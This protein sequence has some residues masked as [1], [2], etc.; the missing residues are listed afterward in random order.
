MI[1]SSGYGGANRDE[2]ASDEFQHEFIRFLVLA[3]AV[4]LLIA[5]A[6]LSVNEA[7]YALWGQTV[8]AQDFK[9]HTVMRSRNTRQV[10]VVRYTF[11][12]GGAARTEEDEVGPDFHFPMANAVDV[13]YIPGTDSSRLLGHHRRWPLY[14][15]GG[16]VLLLAWQA[17]RFWRFYRS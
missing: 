17:W 7:R 8:R 5:S 10:V 4:L 14:V 3:A 15:L 9:R 12:D 6:V 1:F 13:Q 2:E 16:S 11:T